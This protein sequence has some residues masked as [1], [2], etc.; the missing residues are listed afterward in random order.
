MMGDVHV[1]HI[2]AKY[3]LCRNRI[4]RSCVVFELLTETIETLKPRQRQ[5]QQNKHYR[6][7]IAQCIKAFIYK[8][9]YTRTHQTMVIKA[10]ER[11]KWGC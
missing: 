5:Q 6:T 3:A 11:F 4:G 8:N 1:D 9:R 10:L 2:F 7:V